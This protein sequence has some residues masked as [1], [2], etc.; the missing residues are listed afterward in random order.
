M[1][2]WG[3][4]WNKLK[5]YDICRYKIFPDGRITAPIFFLSS[6]IPKRNTLD[7]SKRVYLT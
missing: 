2:L 6:K 1:M 3:E 4:I 7:R 5:K